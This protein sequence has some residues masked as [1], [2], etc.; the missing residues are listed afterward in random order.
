VDSFRFWGLGTGVVFLL[1]LIVGSYLLILIW[2]V[3]SA[4]IAIVLWSPLRAWLEIPEPRVSKPR[5]HRDDFVEQDQ[6][7][8]LV[9]HVALEPLEP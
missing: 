7:L 1:S 8:E 5:T 2:L 9:D 6:E 3:I 4:E